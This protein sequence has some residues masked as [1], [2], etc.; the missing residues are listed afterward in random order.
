[1]LMNYVFTKDRDRGHRIAERVRSGT[2]M[3]NDVC[4]AYGAPE[5][6]FGGVKLSDYGRI[7]GEEGL[8]G[9]CEARHVNYDRIALLRRA[10]YWYPY[11]DRAYRTMS[12]ALK[13]LF[14]RG[15]PVQRLLDMF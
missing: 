2:V 6:P 8:R 3:V 5:T 7:H 1:G 12:K 10:P 13:L 9:M 14:R 4:S 11:S 15:S